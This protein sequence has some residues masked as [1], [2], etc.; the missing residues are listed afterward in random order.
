M[1]PS[2]PV[3]GF[4]P[5][6]I[7]PCSSPQVLGQSILPN[8][9]THQFHLPKTDDRRIPSCT[10]SVLPEE[11]LHH[12]QRREEGPGIGIRS[13]NMGY[14]F[15][16]HTASATC[17]FPWPLTWCIFVVTILWLL[18]SSPHSLYP[19]G[20]MYSCWAFPM[21]IVAWSGQS[22][23]QEISSNDWLRLES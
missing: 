20:N 14:R 9:C 4:I 18:I 1:I 3:L 10:L 2:C 11:P 12:L 13:K 5:R 6:S 16:H 21:S 7:L 23:E 17:L 19:S 8:W 15:K 22:Q